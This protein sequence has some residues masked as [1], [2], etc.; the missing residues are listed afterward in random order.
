MFV[1]NICIAYIVY[2]IPFV[3]W[4]EDHRDAIIKLYGKDIQRD[5]LLDNIDRKSLSPS[6]DTGE[7]LYMWWRWIDKLCSSE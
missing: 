2:I 6:E 1:Y 3:G 7:Q 5:E 4:N